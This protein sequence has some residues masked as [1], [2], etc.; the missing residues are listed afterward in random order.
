MTLL[1]QIAGDF[2]AFFDSNAGFAVDAVYTPMGEDGNP[3]TAK[4]IKV[5]FDAPYQLTEVQ[6]RFA[7]A[8]IS[9]LL[10]T[11][12]LVNLP[13]KQGDTLQ[14][15]DANCYIVGLHSDGTGVSRAI[16]SEDV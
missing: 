13:A 4:T 3:A 14:I 6:E 5:I 1:D 10:K 16:L 12:D 8:V 11:S 15:N 9:A 7:N 2:D